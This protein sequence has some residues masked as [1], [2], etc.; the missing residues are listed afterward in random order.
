MQQPF[1]DDQQGALLSQVETSVIVLD[2]LNDLNVSEVTTRTVSFIEALR[3]H[4]HPTTAIILTEGTPTP[5][6]W[7]SR[8]ISD[9]WSYPARAALR[10][11]YEAIDDT[12]L[13]YVA[14]EDLFKFAPDPL[15]NPTVCGEHP[16]DLGQYIVADFYVRLLSR[17]IGD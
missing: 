12:N 8:S 7:L 17:I 15:V 11:A 14:A 5:G 6:D 16:A 2:C 13:Y 10:T 9:D 4:G 3:A 1:V